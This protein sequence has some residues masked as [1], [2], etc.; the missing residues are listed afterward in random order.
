MITYVIRWKIHKGK[1]SL[2]EG[3]KYL[4]LNWPGHTENI[5]MTVVLVII[6]WAI[7]YLCLSPFLYRVKPQYLIE[8]CG[9]YFI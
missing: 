9:F 8:Y 6:R 7:K 3:I 5:C 2:A 4:I 1:G